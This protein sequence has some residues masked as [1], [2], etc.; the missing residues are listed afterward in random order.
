MSDYQLKD[1]SFSLFVNDNKKHEKS[2]DYMGNIMV[3][4]EKKVMFGYL[5]DSV[6][7]QFI[8]GN[9]ADPLDKNDARPQTQN[10]P[11]PGPSNNPSPPKQ[12]KAAPQTTFPPAQT[13]VEE[14]DDVPF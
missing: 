7:G 11:F 1:N 3:N 10:S 2:P 13:E 8:G 14:E 12:E 4:G 9:V 5:N 6:R